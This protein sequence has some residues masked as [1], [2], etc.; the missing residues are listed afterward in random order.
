[1]HVLSQGKMAMRDAQLIGSCFGTVIH[2]MFDAWHSV[3]LVGQ[4]GQFQNKPGRAHASQARALERPT[5]AGFEQVGTAG[6]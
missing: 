6:A 2:S 4:A 1:M 3:I 5:P